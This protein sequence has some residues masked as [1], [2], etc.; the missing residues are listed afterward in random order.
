MADDV[1]RNQIAAAAKTIANPQAAE[2][3]AEGIISLSH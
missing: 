3:I 2:Q 1:K